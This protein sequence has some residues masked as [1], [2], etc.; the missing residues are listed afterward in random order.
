MYKKILKLN[1][2]FS[3]LDQYVKISN[4]RVRNVANG[5]QLKDVVL[6]KFKYV[7][8]NVSKTEVCSSIN[9]DN[10]LIGKNKKHRT[11]FYKKEC[12]TSMECDYSGIHLYRYWIFVVFDACYSFKR[13]YSH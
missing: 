13:R 7:D 3:N 8:V 6:Y 5:L 2:I 1:E 12:K 9:F 10:E 11:L 4:S